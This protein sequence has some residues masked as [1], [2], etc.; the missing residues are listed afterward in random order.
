MPNKSYNKISHEQKQQMF[1]KQIDRR[2][3]PH[4]K[5][6][7]IT[8]SFRLTPFVIGR[9][10]DGMK[11]YDKNYDPT[12]I[13]KIIKDVFNHGLN[14]LTSHFED[15]KVSDETKLD[16]LE[17]SNQIYI[18]DMEKLTTRSNE[19]KNSNPENCSLNL[20]K[21]QIEAEI[22]NRNYKSKHYEKI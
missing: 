16:L 19:V 7:T 15:G 11:G 6:K 3:K 20:L 14:N 17:L 5:A 9:A 12:N 22:D 1:K 4:K 13:S 2:K 21:Q 18:N 8:V 10:L